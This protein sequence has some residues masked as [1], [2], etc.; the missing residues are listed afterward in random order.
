MAQP[1]A[2]A[3]DPDTSHEAAEW[4]MQRLGGLHKW[5]YKIVSK[6]PGG[7][8]SEMSVAAGEV[9]NHRLSRRLGELEKMGLVVR[10]DARVCRVTG[11]KAAT[12]RPAP[13]QCEL[14]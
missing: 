13:L 7:T 1:L 4:I 10:G 14:F 6:Y 3:T 12:W 11:R 9:T 5:A 8:S 2:R